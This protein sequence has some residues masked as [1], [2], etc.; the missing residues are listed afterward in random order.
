MFA[1]LNT[2]KLSSII[3]SSSNNRFF[4]RLITDNIEDI[5]SSIDNNDFK[6]DYSK[7]IN[8]LDIEHQTKLINHNVNLAFNVNKLNKDIQ[9][10]IINKN[11]MNIQYIQNPSLSI[12]K[13]ANIIHNDINNY[14]NNKGSENL[15]F[16]SHQGEV[17]LIKNN[18]LNLLTIKQPARDTLILAKELNNQLKTHINDHKLQLLLNNTKDTHNNTE[19]IYNN[20]IDNNNY[21]IIVFLFVITMY[22]I[23]DVKAHIRVLSRDLRYIDGDL[24]SISRKINDKDNKD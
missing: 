7:H 21:F 14:I 12:I 4:S 6:F 22:S 15:M 20:T 18:L 2:I 8:D 10:D 1:R 3:K 17:N 9:K 13:T 5:K 24:S 19:D 16:K 11:P 23:D